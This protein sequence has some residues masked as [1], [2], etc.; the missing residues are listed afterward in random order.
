MVQFSGDTPM[1]DAA[2]AVALTEMN[3][4]LEQVLQGMAHQTE[5][6]SRNREDAQ[7][8]IAACR[9]EI[10]ELKV[11]QAAT[12]ARCD[13]LEKAEEGRKAQARLLTIIVGIT[14]TILGIA[15]SVATKLFQ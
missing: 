2:T 3:G 4:K 1:S 6:M 9:T 10:A 5:L 11:E 15:V 14:G 12:D 7:R 13:V 8:D